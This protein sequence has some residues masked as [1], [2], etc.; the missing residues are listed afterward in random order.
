M[1]NIWSKKNNKFDFIIPESTYLKSHENF[2]SYFK[3][4]FWCK[5][6]TLKLFVP[7][8]F[9]PCIERQV[10]HDC[11]QSFRFHDCLRVLH[12]P[13]VTTRYQYL[14]FR[15]NIVWSPWI[16]IYVFLDLRLILFNEQWSFKFSI[17]FRC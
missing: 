8:L 1:L 3:L 10:R 2:D 17:P 7:N 16:Q 12:I 14:V 9:A 5:L 11:V 6:T 13:L 4:T 15:N